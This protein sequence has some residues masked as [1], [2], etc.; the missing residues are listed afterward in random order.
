[1][2][3][4]TVDR[5]ACVGRDRTGPERSAAVP[6]TRGVPAGLIRGIRCRLPAP[7]HL[8][9]S[10][11]TLRR[12]PSIRG[13]RTARLRAGRDRRHGVPGVLPRR[14]GP[15][16]L[17]TRVRD[18]GR[19][20]AR[21]GGRVLRGVLLAHRRSRPDS[22][23]PALRAFLEPRAQADAGHRHGL[24]RAPPGRGDPL[25]GGAVR[26]GPRRA[27]R[28][29]LDDQGPGGRARRCPRPRLPLRAR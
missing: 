13:D 21:L 28:H 20:G 16:P 29:L 22:L 9:R 11:R 6:G 12:R 26:L 1:M 7:P 17:R 10:S 5:G 2:R 15:H 8:R 25:R 19:A 24:R 23:R 18:P 4:H 27:D 14:L 3:Q